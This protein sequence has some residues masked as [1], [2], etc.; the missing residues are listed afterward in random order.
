MTP[1]PVSLLAGRVL[2]SVTASGLQKRHLVGG[3]DPGRFWWRCYLWMLPAGLLVTTVSVAR[4]GLPGTAF[5][6]NAALA[7]ALDALGNLVMMWA[8]R[9]TDLSVFGPLTALRPGLALIFGWI[10]LGE[11]P[12]G[13]G[14]AGLTVTVAGAVLLL[15]GPT[16]APASAGRG[17]A[18]KGIALRVGG[19]A[20]STL[21]SVFLKQAVVSGNAEATL[22][23]WIVVG[24][25]FLWIGTW[26][27]P[28]LGA[29]PAGTAKSPE[30][31][32]D[33]LHAAGFFAMQW[34]TLWVFRDSLL[35]YSFA[36]F[37][38]GMVLQILVGRVVFGEP[39]W[40]RRMAGAAVLGAGAA[41]IL[42]R[43]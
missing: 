16:G 1:V 25:G 2:L 27:L 3:G 40:L 21:A 36:F 37:Q 19:L 22:G 32:W 39:A 31:G 11:W 5:W 13:H 15:G 12:S 6:W 14:L 18:W 8:L 17:G 30:P 24:C 29:L 41:L 43:G 38:T 26:L 34:L 9:R 28:G 42:W 35:A 4:T 7:G 23:V 33:A 20:L 10:F